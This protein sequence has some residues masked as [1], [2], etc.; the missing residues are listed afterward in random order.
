MGEL[1]AYRA[2]RRLMNAGFARVMPENAGPGK[3]S[4]TNPYG[5]PAVGAM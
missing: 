3:R 4:R 5:I 1:G 2:L